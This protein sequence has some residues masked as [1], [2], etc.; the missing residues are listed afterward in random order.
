MQIKNPRI[1]SCAILQWLKRQFQF[2]VA[3]YFWFTFE[4]KKCFLYFFKSGPKKIDNCNCHPN[5]WTNWLL[6]MQR[7]LNYAKFHCSVID[8]K[9]YDS[10]LLHCAPHPPS[11]KNSAPWLSRL[12][13]KGL[14][15]IF[16]H[17]INQLMN[18][19]QRCL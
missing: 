6:V 3:K 17:R 10:L 4:R 9:C 18:E 5:L 1:K 13:G 16:S 19:L 14:L 15:K 8:R 12:G 2:L 7:F 11:V